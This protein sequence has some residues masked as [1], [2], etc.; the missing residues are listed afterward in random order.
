MNKDF[1]KWLVCHCPVE[2]CTERV[3]RSNLSLIKSSLVKK[4]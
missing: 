4:K 2:Y 1:Y 3:G